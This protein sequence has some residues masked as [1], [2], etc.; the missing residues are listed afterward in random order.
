M[1]RPD[2]HFHDFGPFRLDASEHTLLRDGRPVP[3]RPKVFDVLLLLVE[4]H[5]RLVGKDE[6]MRAVWPEQFVE[7]GNLNKTISM[8][9]QALGESHTEHRYI[10]TVPKRGYRFVADVR[11]VEGAAGVSESL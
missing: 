11:A 2:K 4:R 8:L 1:T 5:G 7:E 3:L 9:R 6:L 10:D